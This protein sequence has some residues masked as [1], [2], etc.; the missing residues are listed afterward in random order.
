VWFVKS[1]ATATGF[2]Q[3]IGRHISEHSTLVGSRKNLK[4]IKSHGK[5][6]MG[7]DFAGE[8]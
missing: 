8:N 3:T 5:D 1:I 6:E 7:L 4:Q 2:Y